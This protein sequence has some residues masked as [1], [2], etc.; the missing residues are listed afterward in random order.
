MMAQAIPNS[1]PGS[2]IPPG[3]G[4]TRE[5]MPKAVRKDKENMAK[6]KDKDKR[7][8]EDGED[9]KKQ[10]TVFVKR[11]RITQESL[12]DIS[13]GKPYW[14]SLLIIISYQ[15]SSNVKQCLGDHEPRVG[16]Q[17]LVLPDHGQHHN[18]GGQASEIRL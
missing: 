8:G 3:Q 10:D 2:G 4:K 9:F 11:Q 17:V 6:T 1:G 15:Q 16:E 18:G 7:Q 12:L 13:N 5:D 14:L